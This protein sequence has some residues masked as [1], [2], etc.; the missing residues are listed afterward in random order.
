MTI[1]PL[2]I[3]VA[4]LL[5]ALGFGY[6]IC[7]LSKKEDKDLKQLGHLIG[8]SIIVLSS[9]LTIASIYLRVISFNRLMAYSSMMK[10]NA[11]T[12]APAQK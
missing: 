11:T 4:T 7:C 1:I 8:M 3:T 6:I 5:F 9:V 12:Q 10:S 2:S